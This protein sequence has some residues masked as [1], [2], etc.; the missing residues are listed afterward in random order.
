ML[1]SGCLLAA[2]VRRKPAELPLRVGLGHPLAE[3]VQFRT[4]RSPRPFDHRPALLVSPV[5]VVSSVTGL[6]ALPY[7]PDSY[8][9]T[10]SNERLQ[11]L[12]VRVGT[13]VDG[14]IG[15]GKTGQ[16][17]LA[18]SHTVTTR[19]MSSFITASTSFGCRPSVLSRHCFNAAMAPSAAFGCGR[20]PAERAR[21]WRR[22]RGSAARRPSAS[23]RNCQCKA[24]IRCRGSSA[25]NFLIL[26]KG[27]L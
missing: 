16:L 6:R 5:C 15:C 2:Y 12:A 19:S 13:A 9:I 22:G 14:W 24:Q 18:W 1:V 11:R 8:V 17:S 25:C 4:F 7:Q 27:W 26:V 3:F 21:T 20:V 10:H 23:D